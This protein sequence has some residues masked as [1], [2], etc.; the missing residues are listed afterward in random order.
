MADKTMTLEDAVGEVR[1]GMTVGIGGWGSR[2]KPMA[3]V[4]AL[5]RSGVKDLTIVS[6][7]GPDVGILCATGQARKVVYGFVSLDSIALEPH[8][9]NARQAGTIEA[10]SLDEGMFRLG[11]QAAAWR[12]PFLPTRAGLGS[13]VLVNQPQIR[14]VKSP[15]DD[16]EELVAIPAQRLDVAFIHMN[17]AD[18]AGNGQYLGRD[19]YMD[20]LFCMAAD[21]AFMS[22]EKIVP[23]ANLLDEGTFHTLKINRMMVQGVVHAPG[24]AHFTE[25]PP[26]YERDEAFQKEYAA[27]AKD[28]ASWEA[29]KAKYLDV[30]EDEYQK[31]VAK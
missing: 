16:G 31:A 14:T 30:T 9:R 25:C 26:D 3:F 2:R 12:L 20:E 10:V 19:P 15:Y 28:A 1:D 18:T 21:K 13:D 11:L 8:F 24:G 22:A 7:G 6:Y 17:R 4:R 5:V 23:T 29:W 27:S